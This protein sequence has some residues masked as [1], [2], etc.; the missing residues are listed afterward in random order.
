M[1]RAL[2]LALG[3]P[4]SRAPRGLGGGLETGSA[5]ST[6][7]VSRTSGWRLDA[8]VFEEPGQYKGCPAGQ[9]NARENECLA[10]VTAATHAEGLALAYP[11]AVKYVDRGPDDL[12][13]GGCSYSKRHGQRAMWNRN[14]SGRSTAS[15]P[16]VSSTMSFSTSPAPHALARDRPL[17]VG[18]RLD[19]RPSRPRGARAVHRLPRRPAQ[20]GGERVR[21][22]GAGRSAVYGGDLGAPRSQGGGRRGRR[23]GAGW[24]LVLPRARPA[25]DVQPEPGRPQLRLVLAGVHRRRHR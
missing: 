17:R 11:Y 10:A 7:L 19:P 8:R 5:G 9:R 25:G 4:A 13:P 16:L 23:V 22:R 20:R 14:P 6:A 3:V 12:V 18:G 2:G 15:Y 1:L 24:L 21:G